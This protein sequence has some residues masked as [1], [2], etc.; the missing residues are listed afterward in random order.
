MFADKRLSRLLAVAFLVSITPRPLPAPGK[1]HPPKDS[2][3][4]TKEVSSSTPETC[5]VTQPPAQ[6]FLPPPP[7]P[8]QHSSEGF[9]FGSEKL[10]VQLPKDGI[11]HLPHNG[12]PDADF[13]QKIQWWRKDY[14]WRTDMPSKLKVTGERIDSPAPHLASH[15]KASGTTGRSFIM[16]GLNIP[17]LG[18]WQITGNYAGDKLTF[19]IWVAP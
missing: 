4:Q 15:S 13:G 12:P 9:W 17:T 3:R 6:A 7:Y 5:P 1:S 19:V 2:I 8:S 14:E 10:W 18:C 11:S 16:S